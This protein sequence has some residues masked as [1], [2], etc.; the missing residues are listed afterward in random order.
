M[1]SV[2]FNIKNN[3][4]RLYLASVRKTSYLLIIK[5][6]WKNEKITIFYSPVYFQYPVVCPTIFTT[7][8]HRI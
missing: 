6:H 5:S 4:R 7:I 1:L 8:L 3:N 2:I